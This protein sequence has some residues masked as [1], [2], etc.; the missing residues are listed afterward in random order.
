[1]GL[2]KDFI[3]KCKAGMEKKSILKPSLEDMEIELKETV[4][5]GHQAAEFMNTELFKKYIDYI[6][7]TSEAVI[8]KR[9]KMDDLEEK[10]KFLRNIVAFFP[11]QAR[12]GDAA[13]ENLKAIEPEIQTKKLIESRKRTSENRRA[14]SA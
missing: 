1:M 8:S 9:I 5:V 6:D 3:S 2:I 4:I 12:R 13:R 14:G 10:I 11:L 7:E